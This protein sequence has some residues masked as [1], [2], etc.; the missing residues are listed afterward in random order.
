MSFSRV[1]IANRGE[2]ARRIQASCRRLGLETV[3]VFSQADRDALFVAEADHAICIGPASPAESYLKIEAILDA[4]RTSGAGAI[5]PGYGFLSENPE[6]AAAVEAAGL[7]YVGP[8]SEAIRVM[9]SKITAKAAAED[10]GVPTLPGYR[11][12]DQSDAALLAAAEKLGVPFLV[13]ASAGGGGRGMRLVE[14]LGDAAQ[15]IASARTEAKG[16]FGDDTVFL[17]RY[18]G[19]ARHIEVQV[20]GDTHGNHLHLWDRDC[21]LQRNHQKLIEEAPAPDLP[22][23]ARQVMLDAA[24]GL[25]KAINYRSAGTVEYLYDPADQA[26]YFLEMN[27]RIQV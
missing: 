9:G 8:T 24:V 22:E 7:V 15:A 12:D 23:G 3:A 4:A 10:A 27:T 26:V 21:S 16:A 18:L 19:R 11:G 17:E 13:K 20:L 25:G 5:H 1:L 14:D 6:F 2:I